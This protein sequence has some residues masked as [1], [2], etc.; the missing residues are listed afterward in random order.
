ML[1][2]VPLPR[3]RGGGK[4]LQGTIRWRAPT[5]RAAPGL[6]TLRRRVQ[7]LG[8]KFS[9]SFSFLGFP[10]SSFFALFCAGLAGKCGLLFEL[11]LWIYS[12]SSFGTAERE[13]ILEI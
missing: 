6:P 11:S 13:A 2:M 12:E 1:R 5:G 4:A 7:A 8:G 10:F 3:F 9:P